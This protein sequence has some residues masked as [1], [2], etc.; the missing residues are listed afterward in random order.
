MTTE[1]NDPI[2]LLWTGG[3]DS[4]YRLLELILAY[5]ETVR[6][7]YIIDTGR[8]SVGNELR[9][10]GKI[11]KFL[12][13]AY[14]EASERLLQTSY[15]EVS[16]IKPDAEITKAFKSVTSTEYL[17]GQYEWL[18]RYCKERDIPSIEI[19]FIAKPA[20]V[21]NKKSFLTKITG[22]DFK[23]RQHFNYAKMLRSSTNGNR[24]SFSFDPGLCT[25][26]EYTVFRYFSPTIRDKTK[27]DIK[28][29]VDRNGWCGLMSLTWFCH[30]PLFGKYPC[31]RCNPCTDAIQ[32]GMGERVP[33]IGKIINIFI[34]IFCLRALK[35]IFSS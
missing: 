18:A 2:D 13:N 15:A 3:W 34:K 32:C 19:G 7:H 30:R 17:G 22:G 21:E 35:K 9:A 33:L 6:P 20:D 25:E 8:P 12:R 4:T 26:A 23:G 31:G 5:G 11:K 28:H 14:P 16:D 27:V 10:M 24:T 29:I 1:K